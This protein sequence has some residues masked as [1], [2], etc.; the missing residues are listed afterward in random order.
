[1]R[2]K[3]Y[4]KIYLAFLGITLLSIPAAGILSHVVRDR[5]PVPHHVHEAV[6]L[7]AEDLEGPSTEQRLAE[8]AERLGLVLG[9]YDSE[10]QQ[11]A[12]AGET[13][14]PRKSSG[15]HWVHGPTGMGLA[16]DLGDGRW[17]VS[18]PDSEH[19]RRAPPY[20]LVL[21]PLALLMALGTYPVARGIT[22]R[23]E[24][25]RGKV[26]ELGGGD[27]GARVPVKGSD[28]VA[29]LA[30]SFNRAAD[31]IEALVEG[32]R[33]MLASASHELRSPLARLQLSVE[34]AREA[35]SEDE[36]DQ[37]RTE[38]LRNIEE[39]DRLIEDLLLVGRLETGD[40]AVH[41]PVELLA[42]AAEEAARVEATAGGREATVIGD[43]ALLRILLRNLLENAV[44]HG[45]PP[46]E[47]EVEVHGDRVRLSVIDQ[48]AGV[49]DPERER[50]FEPFYRPADRPEGDGGGTGLGL[51]L[52]RRIAHLH[53]GHAGCE[54]GEPS[55]FVVEFPLIN[56]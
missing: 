30:T 9:L 14:K 56:R 21:L 36:R 25:L 6:E 33:R 24:A 41:E 51:A 38:A 43:A 46:V 5:G 1:M 27:L 20:L 26:D 29:A 23:I 2:H 19:A 42:L 11:I 35:R 7:F 31:R 3:L 48:G 53:G 49:P 10:G 4:L 32:Q 45:Q 50:V 40:R 55:R 8:R 39:L 37:H 16:V 13:A 34:L 12:A 47:V 52:V 15:D 44:K 54:P 18:A 22:R 17:L 28:E